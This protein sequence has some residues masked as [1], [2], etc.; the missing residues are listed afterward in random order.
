MRLFA[1]ASRTF[2]LALVVRLALHFG[3]SVV[4]FQVGVPVV[5]EVLDDFVV[6]PSAVLPYQGDSQSFKAWPRDCGLAA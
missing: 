1:Y 5:S 4:M 2:V 3:I 6:R